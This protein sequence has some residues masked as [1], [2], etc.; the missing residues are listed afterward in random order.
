MAGQEEWKGVLR[1]SGK[2]IISSFRLTKS[3]L[4]LSTIHKSRGSWL[5]RGKVGD[6]DSMV[7]LSRDAVDLCVTG[8]D[9]R[10]F[11]FARGFRRSLKADKGLADDESQLTEPL[12]HSALPPFPVYNPVRIHFNPS[13]PL[14]HQP[15]HPYYGL[16]FLSRSFI[17]PT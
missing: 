14:L 10:A 2:I 4:T 5:S 8:D 11:C 16:C 15:T 7:T 9:S 12:I 1:V 3:F 17:E 6:P 13:C